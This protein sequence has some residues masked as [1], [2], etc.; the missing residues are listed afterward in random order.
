MTTCF[1]ILCFSCSQKASILEL[2]T[3]LDEERELRREEREK[4]D[5]NLKT[6][7]QKVQAESQEEMRRLSD[8]ASKREKEQKELIHKLQVCYIKVS[9]F[10]CLS[11]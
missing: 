2:E 3:L 10:I 5:M 4:A 11:C 1:L 7:I 9:S 6:S 8:A